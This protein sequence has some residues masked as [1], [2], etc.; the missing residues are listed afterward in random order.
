[1]ITKIFDES[2]NEWISSTLSPNH[3]A[4]RTA[5]YRGKLV[6]GVDYQMIRGGIYVRKQLLKFSY[7]K[8]KKTIANS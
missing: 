3:S 2:G 5:K 8:L 6:E 1:M 7:R 4:I